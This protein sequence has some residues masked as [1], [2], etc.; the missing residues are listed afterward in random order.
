MAG[1][2]GRLYCRKRS[3]IKEAY[4]TTV[5]DRLELRVWW[6]LIIAA[7]DA[8]FDRALVPDQR[9]RASYCLAQVTDEHA[10]VR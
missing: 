4:Q 6:G 2:F 9:D 7:A 1:A 5:S 3:I 10:A 8:G